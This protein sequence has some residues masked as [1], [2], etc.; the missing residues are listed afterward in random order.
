MISHYN[1]FPIYITTTEHQRRT[2]HKRRI[3]KKWRKKYGMIEVDVMSPGQI[4]MTND[5]AIWMTKGTFKSL[6][7][8]GIK[9][10]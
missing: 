9:V 6:C 10:D 2:H 3:N 1:G 8:L 4:I 5:G 7:E